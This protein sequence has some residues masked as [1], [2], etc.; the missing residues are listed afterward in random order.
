MAAGKLEVIVSAKID[1][2]QEGLTK[3]EQS[4]AE[5]RAKVSKLDDTMSKFQA[6]AM[7]ATKTLG[8]LALAGVVVSEGFKSVTRSVHL[9]SAGLALLT[10][11]TTAAM[12]S[13]EKFGDS[14][15]EIP[16]LGSIIG[17]IADSAFELIDVFAGVTREAERLEKQMQATFTSIAITGQ[18]V[19]LQKQNNLLV[20][21]LE[22]ARELND[23][24]K[25]DLQLEIDLV[26]LA[27]QQARRRVEIT[28]HGKADAEATK[29]ALE[30]LAANTALQED[31][32]RAKANQ[33]KVDI[34]IAESAERAADAEKRKLERLQEQQALDAFEEQITGSERLIKQ[35]ERE[36]KILSETD[37]L[38]RAG[39]KHQDELIKLRN[40]TL[41]AEEAIK[42]NSELTAAQKVELLNLLDR[43]FK[44]AKQIL[45]IEAEQTENA[46]KRAREEEKIN[47]LKERQREVV[48]QLEADNVASQSRLGEIS[49]RLGSAATQMKSGLTETANTAMGSFTFGEADAQEKIRT[50]NKEQ[51]DIQREIERR[52]ARIE[53]L[54][55]QISGD[56]GVQ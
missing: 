29:V 51:T 2:L 55:E 1:E 5:T 47:A 35:L 19:E 46:I 16:I 54:L 52:S 26:N 14:I 25:I 15:R 11:N 6:T 21:Q 23:N 4:V 48:K 53:Q 38:K 56:F 24:R 43:E 44:A 28:K 8:A 40:R 39:L 22:L 50:L 12:K 7:K 34:G 42:K 27:E 9:S 49:N 17:G 10:G 13:L 18:A 45:D 36:A 20:T 37:E 41:D 3:V 31:I 32:L 30:Q 33:A